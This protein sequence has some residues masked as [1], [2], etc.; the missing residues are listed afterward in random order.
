MVPGH[1]RAFCRAMIRTT[2]A[3]RCL[4][5]ALL[6]GLASLALI[7]LTLWSERRAS[8]ASA[9]HDP[10]D[11]VRP[12]AVALDLALLSLAGTPDERVLALAL[13][14]YE[15]ETARVLLTFGADLGDQ[16]RLNGWLWLAY[17][18]QKAGQTQRAARAYRLAG[19]GAV[20]S[21]KLP[22]L[23]RVEALLTIGR[24]LIALHDKPGAHFYL[25]QAALISAHAPDLTVH[26][27]RSLLERLIPFS[28]QAG[29]RR[30]DWAAL[31]QAIAK[32]AVPQGGKSPNC[33]NAAPGHDAGLV[34]A[35]DARRAAAAAW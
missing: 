6:V 33:P 5:A 28:L 9:W 31:A 14:T 7:L 1:H 8:A 25:K 17:R 15:L 10:A 21:D 3:R 13:E 30:N 22:D 23:L 18:Y 32:D 26:H 12:D 34:R 20:L 4:Q 35:Q 24:Q 27:R 29:G 16:Q 11:D 19:G 2:L